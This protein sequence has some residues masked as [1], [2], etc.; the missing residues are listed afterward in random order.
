MLQNAIVA[1]EGRD[2]TRERYIEAYQKLLN[3][4]ND[5]KLSQEGKEFIRK[6]SNLTKNDV[7]M[8]SNTKKKLT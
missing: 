4:W 3:I 7:G 2:K 6:I 5:G 8:D 1:L